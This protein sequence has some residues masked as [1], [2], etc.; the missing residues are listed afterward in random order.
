MRPVLE[1]ARQTAAFRAL[2][3]R[4]DSPLGPLVWL[5]IQGLVHWTSHG[6]GI[7][8][9]TVARYVSSTDQ[10]RL[11]LGSGPTTLPGWLNSDLVSGD[12]YIDV[13]RPLPL[14]DASF[15][16]VFME[17]LI[18]HVSERAGLQLLQEVHRVLRPGGTLRVTTPDL[19]KIIALYEDRNEAMT[20]ADY[21]RFLDEMTG[22]RHER[23]CQVFND[24]MRLWGHRYVYDE[25]D[26][27]VKLVA[28]G[29]RSIER[30]EPGDSD[31]VLLRGLEHHGPAWEN[32]VEAMCLEATRPD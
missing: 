27:S 16:Y 24:F 10:P 19:K 9:R 23:A 12:V 2:K 21:S 15:S 17:H 13:A 3:Q 29:F 5:R 31:H 1:R 14:P 20:L 6:H 30:H 26:L 11:Q 8:S 7:R 25:E 4:V 32:D 18:E 28:T 22:R